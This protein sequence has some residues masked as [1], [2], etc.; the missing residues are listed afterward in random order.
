M[1][2]FQARVIIE[3]WEDFLVIRHSQ[4]LRNIT[5]LGKNIKVLAHFCRYPW[6]GNEIERE[7][8][9]GMAA[10]QARFLGLTARKT[11]TEYE[12]Q[13]I[14]QQR[15]TLSNQSSNYYNQLLGMTVPTPPSTQDFT[16]TV[17]TFT[18]GALD[19]TITSMIAQTDGTYIISYTRKWTD[20]FAAISAGSTVVT[21]TGEEGNYSYMVGSVYLRNLGEMPADPDNDPYFSTLNDEQ[22]QKALAEEQEYLTKLNDKYGEANWQV[23]YNYNTTTKT[24]S[25][26]FY[27][28]ED[29]EK[30]DVLYGENGASLS[31]IPCYTIGAS[32]ETEE[33]KGAVARFEQD[34]TGRFMSIT[35]YEQNDDGTLSQ[36]VTYSLTTN[37]TTDQDAYDDAMNQ[38][39]F[40]KNQYDH[41]IQEINA[42]IEL[43]Q[44]QDKNLELRL[45]QLDTEQNAIQTEMDAVQKVIEKNTESTFKTFG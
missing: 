39:E 30:K 14:N 38:Y 6:Q 37:T 23:R 24:W 2:F 3:F 29:L 21:R 12:G 13:Q 42:K 10:S 11:N 28:K 20:N 5:I 34:S 33:V 31:Y 17:Y 36:P 43:I 26:Y 16:K 44:A 18:D 22:R 32:L 25:P 4:L 27:K 9:M 45:K 41:S 19:N 15:T 40:D 8:V 1:F 7:I 35:L